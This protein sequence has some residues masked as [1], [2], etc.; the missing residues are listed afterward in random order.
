VVD[1]FVFI[2]LGAWTADSLVQR[3][4]DL[5]LVRKVMQVVGLLGSASFFWCVQYAGAATTALGL[6]C[7]VMGSLALTWSGFGPNHMD[8][9]PR[10]ADVVMGITNT[11]GSLP[12]VIGIPWLVQTTGTYAAA[13]M[14]VAAIQVVGAMVWLI[15]STA[16]PVVD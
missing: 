13:F 2:I 6:M 14:L 9:A 12:G 7:G 11:A 8:I 5:T 10:Y 3:G 15:F 16:R 1:L 4:I